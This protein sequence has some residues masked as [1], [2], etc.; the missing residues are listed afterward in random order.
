M[1]AADIDSQP[2]TFLTILL[3]VVKFDSFNVAK[4]LTNFDFNKLFKDF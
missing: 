4:V 2:T 3:T 1:E